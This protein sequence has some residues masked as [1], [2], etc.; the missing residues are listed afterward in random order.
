MVADD[1][2]SVHSDG[3]D[4]EGG[5]DHKDGL[6]RRLKVAQKWNVSPLPSLIHDFN[7]KQR[8]NFILGFS[9]Y[10]RLKCQNQ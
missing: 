7:L 6:K 2:A 1:D 9:S 3:R 4:G 8:K 5:D 10:L